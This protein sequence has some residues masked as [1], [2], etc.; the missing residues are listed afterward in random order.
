[1]EIEREGGKR[2]NGE[3]IALT[4]PYVG[5][6]RERVDAVLCE[7]M[8]VSSDRSFTIDA[9]RVFPIERSANNLCS[10][11]KGKWGVQIEYA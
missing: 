4:L 2:K 5:L 7:I 9:N 3:V 8:S 6:G 1:M 10:V 11:A